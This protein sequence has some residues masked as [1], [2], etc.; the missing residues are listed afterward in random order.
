MCSKAKALIQYNRVNNKVRR[1]RTMHCPTRGPVFNATAHKEP[2][3]SVWHH[4]QPAHP[5]SSSKAHAISLTKTIMHFK[6]TRIHVELRGLLLQCA[7]ILKPSVIKLFV[8]KIS[9]SLATA[10]APCYRSNFARPSYP[11]IHALFSAVDW[12]LLLA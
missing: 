2:I 8:L 9:L 3:A 6:T 4:K 12:N 10:S 5:H 11:S 7:L 1:T